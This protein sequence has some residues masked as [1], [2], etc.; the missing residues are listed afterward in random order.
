MGVRP[1]NDDKD[2]AHVDNRQHTSVDE[3]VCQPP[4]RPGY[5]AGQEIGD[6]GHIAILG[7]KSG[8]PWWRHQMET[9]FALLALCAGNSP[10]T[11][12]FPSQRAVTGSFDIF[13][14]MRLNKQLSKQSKRRWFE[15]PLRSLWRR[16]YALRQH[17]RW[18][19]VCGRNFEIHF[20]HTKSVWY[21][22]C[23][24]HVIDGNMPGCGLY[25]KITCSPLHSPGQNGHFADDIFKCIFM[26]EKLCILFRI[27]L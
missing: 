19:T 13:F 10:V 14:D 5:C 27:S 7:G 3:M 22:W 24:S 25:K 18:Q 11:G 4:G 12:E 26:N 21:L 16:C 8:T 9:F 2:L 17:A 6:G 15:T 20:N 23:L 1:T